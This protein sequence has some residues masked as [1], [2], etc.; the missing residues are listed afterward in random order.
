MRSHFNKGV[1]LWNH[2]LYLANFIGVIPNLIH[3]C[4][5][6]Q[7]LRNPI[8]YFKNILFIWIN[9]FEVQR[10]TYLLY[11]LW[12]II[13]RGNSHNISILYTHMAFRAF[14]TSKPIYAQPDSIAILIKKKKDVLYLLT[15]RRQIWAY[16]IKTSL[17]A[18]A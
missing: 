7:F 3:K 17:L 5:H 16:S 2:Y 13:Q 9:P 12:L 11:Y 14:P 15:S 6:I 4:K 1:I 18:S 8:L 10:A